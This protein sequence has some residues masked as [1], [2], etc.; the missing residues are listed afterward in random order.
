MKLEIIL[1]QYLRFCLSI[2]GY[3]FNGNLGDA[4]RLAA[5]IVHQEYVNCRRHSSV[6]NK[7]M[8]LYLESIE[9]TLSIVM[10]IK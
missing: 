3:K 10:G 7:L 5:P 4:A 8:K 6:E 1:L 2:V 9:C